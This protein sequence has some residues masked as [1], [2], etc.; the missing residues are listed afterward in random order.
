MDYAET[1]DRH[2]P[3]TSDG[4]GATATRSRRRPLIALV[5]TTELASWLRSEIHAN[6]PY[7]CCPNDSPL[8]YKLVPTPHYRDRPGGDR[9]RPGAV[10]D[11]RG[12]VPIMD[13]GNAVDRF[14]AGDQVAAG[15]DNPGGAAAGLSMITTVDLAGEWVTR[16]MRRADDDGQACERGVVLAE[17]KSLRQ[18][19]STQKCSSSGQHEWMLATMS[20]FPR[21]HSAGV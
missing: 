10:R 9:T 19:S 20:G 16:R 4:I 13:N 6:G 21:R 7:A 2:T 1:R 3:G 15:C 12:D 11:R 8:L 5:R 17:A 18:L 14:G